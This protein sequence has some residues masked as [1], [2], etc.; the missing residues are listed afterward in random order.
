MKVK[1][2]SL[3]R[4]GTSEYAPLWPLDPDVVYL[5]HGSFGACPKWILE[6]QDAYR[7]KLEQEP[8][9]FILRE[10]EPMQQKAREKLAEFT[11]AH[12][13]DVV[14]VQNATTA[15]NTVFRSLKFKPGDEILITNHIYPACRRTLEYVCEQTGA[16]LREACNPFPLDDPEQIAEA[17]LQAVTPKVRI[18]LIDHI[19]AATALVQPVKE[20][21]REL[22][23]RGIDTMVDGAH[24]LGTVPI[25]LD[26]L[27]AA[28]Y[29]GNCHKWLCAPK[30]SAILHIRKDKQKGIVPMV[31]SHAGA[32]AE[33]FSE[34]FFW[35]ATFDPS[36]LLCAPDMVDY[37]G[38]L[39]PGG[40]T[41]VMDRNRNLCLEARNILCNV[42]DVNK[43]TPDLMVASLA[44]V[45]LP[46]PDKI[47]SSGYK[48]AD[49]LQTHLFQEYGIEV[50]VWYWGDPP[51]RLLRI[52]AQLYNNIEQY[53]YLGERL[54]AFYQDE[55]ASLRS[56]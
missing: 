15:V 6:R 33:P 46:T 35:P 45:L 10:F 19:T 55:V 23:K 29:T 27:G 30:A 38:S 47:P 1:N 32:H 43:P 4:P 3:I 42:L 34:R 40:W 51:K 41:E 2:N 37:V 11:G 49:P 44:T 28:Y 31:I 14:F 52:S 20:I 18:A 16:V 54:S 48:G 24:A 9:R 21:V 13:D 8:V 53:R 39:L 26:D 36:P 50:P 7:M 12:A 56:Q 5:N 17:I 25:N 22:D